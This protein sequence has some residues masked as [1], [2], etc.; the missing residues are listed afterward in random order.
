[1]YTTILLNFCNIF[2]TFISIFLSYIILCF[3][4]NEYTE[5]LNNELMILKELN[6]KYVELVKLR[7]IWTIR[8]RF[9]LWCLTPLSTI[10]QLYH[11]VSF[12]GG[13]NQTTRRKPPLDILNVCEYKAKTETKDSMSINWLH[14]CWYIFY[15]ANSRFI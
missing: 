14:H 13:G 12:I 6:T 8:Y 3:V 7:L 4:N 5:R 9:G 15:K 2:S 1:M 10:F 11:G